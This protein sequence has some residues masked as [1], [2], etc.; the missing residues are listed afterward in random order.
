[1]LGGPP[2]SWE[3]AQEIYRE[4]SCLFGTQQSL[5]RIAERG[6]FG[7]E[8]INYIHKKHEAEKTRGYCTCTKSP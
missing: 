7:H 1:M 6:G 3:R 5:K 2:I 4:Y 8:E